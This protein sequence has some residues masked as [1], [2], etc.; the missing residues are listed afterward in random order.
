MD[1]LC[2]T[3]EQF[4]K[5]A[6]V[7]LTPLPLCETLKRWE[8]SIVE[9]S[10]LNHSKQKYGDFETVGSE[11]KFEA[12]KRNVCTSSEKRMVI[13]RRRKFGH[14]KS[15]AW[16]LYGQQGDWIVWFGHVGIAVIC[17]TIK[18]L[19]LSTNHGSRRLSR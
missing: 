16:R 9:N 15:M 14:T 1:G 4:S 8:A 19:E 5:I 13:P 2:S 6:E 7:S 10:V 11:G 12:T 18:P 17:D 3:C